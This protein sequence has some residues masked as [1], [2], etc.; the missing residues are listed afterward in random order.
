[1]RNSTGCIAV[2][3][4]G[5]TKVEPNEKFALNLSSPTNAVI[6][7][8]QGIG[9]ILNDDGSVAATG[10]VA[11]EGGEEPLYS[12]PDDSGDATEAAAIA[13]PAILLGANPVRGPLRVAFALPEDGP[14]RVTV[15]DLQGRLVRELANAR[16][17][18]GRHDLGLATRDV[19]LVPGVYFA[20]LE[21]GGRTVVQRFVTL[22]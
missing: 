1:M 5:D 17:S 10:V 13:E 8:M 21:A 14:A 4:N 18:A 2:T 12:G 11:L 9:T 19:A 15:V 16:F 22:R 7:D 20:R 3:V 6:G